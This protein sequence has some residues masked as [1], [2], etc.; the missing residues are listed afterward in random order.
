VRIDPVDLDGNV[1]DRNFAIGIGAS[2]EP[3]AK[4]ILGGF[5]LEFCSFLDNSGS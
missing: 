5:K 2:L 1:I 3:E 4:N